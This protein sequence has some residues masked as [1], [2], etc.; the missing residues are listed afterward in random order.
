M[1]TDPQT[2]PQTT[3][4]ARGAQIRPR[5]RL[6]GRTRKTVLVLHILAAAAWFGVD[7]MVAVFVLAGWFSG[8]D[9]VRAVAYQALGTFALWPMLV[10]GLTSL[11][12]GVLLGLGSRYGLV[13]YW[14]V[15]VKLALNLVLCGLIIVLLR[16]ELGR[17]GPYGRELADGTAGEHDVSQ[18]FFPPAVSLSALSFATALA[19]FK[20]W[21]RLRR[22]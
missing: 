17:L 8:D 19:V 10:S 9:G 12:T 6:R 20:P 11:G 4:Q 18:L 21:G 5:W 7:I 13:R 3:P 22:R 1:T 16:P 2:T 15:A 14:W